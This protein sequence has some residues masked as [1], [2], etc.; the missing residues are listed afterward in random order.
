MTLS[1]VVSAMSKSPAIVGGIVSVGPGNERISTVTPSFSKKPRSTAAKTPAKPTHESKPTRNTGVAPRAVERWATMTAE[2]PSSV[3]GC[4]LIRNLALG[5]SIP[6]YV[7]TVATHAARAR[8]SPTRRGG[9]RAAVWRNSRR[10]VGRIGGD[11]Q[12]PGPKLPGFHA[13]CRDR[14]RA[15]GGG[16]ARARPSRAHPHHDGRA[17]PHVLYCGVARANQPHRLRHHHGG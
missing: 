5:D 13:P 16:G 4:I 2:I 17:V 9:R 6:R 12:R 15:D 1:G 3:I 14:G 11:S 7:G 8:S 10:I